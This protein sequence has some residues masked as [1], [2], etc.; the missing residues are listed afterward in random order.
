MLVACAVCALMPPLPDPEPSEWI[1]SEGALQ[2]RKIR[3]EINRVRLPMGHEGSYGLIRHPGAA[4][5]VPVT[6]GG[7][8][9][10]LRQYRFA[11]AR[12]LLEFPAGTLEEGEDPLGSMKREL[13][14][15]AGYSASRW[16][17]LGQLL[18]CPG[19]SDEVIH[20][21]LARELVSLAE[22]PPG[23]ADED[24]EILHMSPAELDVRLAS[25]EEALDG[26]SVTA[27]Y[28]A[29]QVLGW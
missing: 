16:D 10:I 23:D 9:V 15:E 12:R 5:A 21:F 25:G 7:Q 3:F 18:P 2:A 24:L 11:V 14:E 20:L 29:R 26:K 4:L 19:Y 28:R 13:G 6:D 22:R 8:V 1:G 17:D 27:W